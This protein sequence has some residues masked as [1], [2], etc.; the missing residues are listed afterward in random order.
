MAAIAPLRRHRPRQRV[1]RRPVV[2]PAQQLGLAMARATAPTT[3][4]LLHAALTTETA[5]RVHRHHRRRHLPCLFRRR[6]HSALAVSPCSPTGSATWHAT[7]R[8]ASLTVE[9]ARTCLPRHCLLALC[10]RMKSMERAHGT[11]RMGTVTMAGTVQ[12]IRIAPMALTAP[13]VGL[14]RCHPAPL[15]PRRPH[16]SQLATRALTIRRRAAIFWMATATMA[17][18]VQSIPCAASVLIAQTADDAR[19]RRLRRRRRHCLPPQVRNVVT[20]LSNAATRAT[21][22]A[23][24]E[25]RALSIVHVP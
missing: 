10:A 16:L 5:L 9:L 13:I 6:H 11:L 3:A 8:R 14:A 17:G 12:S 23:M 15:H 22:T 24:M 19:R 4:T 7:Y 25:V 2:A 21:E 1:H 18:T 20:I